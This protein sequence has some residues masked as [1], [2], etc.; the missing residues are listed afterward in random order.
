MF[1]P[2]DVALVVRCCAPSPQKEEGGPSSSSSLGDGSVIA[3]VALALFVTL[4]VIADT[5]LTVVITYVDCCET[6][7]VYPHP[8]PR[9]RGRTTSP[10]PRH[11]FASAASSSASLLGFSHIRLVTT[12][13]LFAPSH[14]HCCWT[15]LRHSVAIFPRSSI[16]PP[17]FP[18]W[19]HLRGNPYRRKKRQKFLFLFTAQLL[20]KTNLAE[21]ITEARSGT[22]AHKN[23]KR[24]SAGTHSPLIVRQILPGYGSHQQL[25]QKRCST[26]R[27]RLCH[28]AQHARSLSFC[29]KKKK[30]ICLPLR[31]WS[32][33]SQGAST[34]KFNSQIGCSFLSTERNGSTSRSG[35][36]RNE[37]RDED[38]FK[39]K[40]F[41]TFF[42]I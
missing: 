42:F 17:P 40:I 32:H 13:F 26:L 20:R 22:I 21:I 10:L 12:W 41:V 1:L 18:V 27:N 33:S 25:T 31:L 36:R 34:S 39:L 8:L 7:D 29:L 24:I 23:Q 19:R 15:I 4:V 2:V 9:R 3:I 16:A 28:P 30:K 14:P 11:G 5:A 35:S 6:F 38:Q 37:K